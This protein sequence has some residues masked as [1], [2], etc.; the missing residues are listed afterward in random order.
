MA[1]VELEDI[2]KV[3]DNGHVAVHKASFDIDDGEGAGAAA[4]QSVVPEVQ[5]LGDVFRR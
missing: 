5:H 2:R 4:G 1:K 3:Y